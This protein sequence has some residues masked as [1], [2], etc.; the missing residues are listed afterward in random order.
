MFL[1]TKLTDGSKNAG[2]LELKRSRQRLRYEQVDL[3]QLHNV[4]DIRQDLAPFRDWKAEGFCRYIGIT[5]TF[6]NDYAAAEAV[7]AA[8]NP[9]SSKSI[10]RWATAQPKSGCY[11]RRA[12]P[13]PRY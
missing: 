3:L 12:M 8:R 7:L 2:S 1:A 6:K 11:R 5:T 10:I 9:T 4:R 13:A